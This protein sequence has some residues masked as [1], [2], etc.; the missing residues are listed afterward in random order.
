MS[1]RLPGGIVCPIVTPLTEDERLDVPALHRLLDRILPDLDGLFVLGTSGEY[2]LLRPQ[3]AE[4]L[5]DAVIERA[6]GR[7][8]IYAG[9]GD[10]GTAR[11]IE[12]VRRLARRGVDYVF[13]CGPFYY[14]IDDQAQLERH[15]LTLAEAATLPLVL[16]NIPQNTVSNLAPATVARLAEH[17]NIVGLKDSWGD[18]IQFGAY[19]AAGSDAFAV[20]QGREQ[21]AAASLWQGAAGVVSGLAN[22]APDLLQAIVQAVRAGDRERAL[23]LQRRADALSA[24]FAQG[25]W[26]G[27]LKTAVAELGAG[28]GRVA[29]PIPPTTVQ[30]RDAIRAILTA[31]GRLPL[32][33]P[34]D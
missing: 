25:H 33:A 3:V 16:Y 1:T 14:P 17:P 4:H 21:L 8:A 19:L 5:V 26:L 11:A 9:V 2:A 22:L 27:A 6:G 18:M 7:A 13:A 23:D 34:A 29:S 31:H 10:T 24:V 12:N 32:R 15:F 30:Q 20:M 28:T